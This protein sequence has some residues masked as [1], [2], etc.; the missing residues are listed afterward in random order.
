VR[1]KSSQYDAKD[2][3]HRNRETIQKA[4]EDKGK[5]TKG[6]GSHY[7]VIKSNIA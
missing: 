4:L 1:D 6:E 3:K 7:L 2:K 5:E